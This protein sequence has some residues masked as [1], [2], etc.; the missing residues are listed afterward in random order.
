MLRVA[1][2]GPGLT[3]SERQRVFE[4]FYR[5]GRSDTRGLGLGLAI[6]RGLIRAQGGSITIESVLGQGT[7]VTV[8]LPTAAVP[9]LVGSG[10]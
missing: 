3:E 5:A 9:A 2:N 6:C 8:G 4:P 1:D 7:T 10:R